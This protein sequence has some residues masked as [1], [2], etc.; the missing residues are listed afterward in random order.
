VPES[1]VL[2]DSEFVPSVQ[3]VWIARL[4]PPATPPPLA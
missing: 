1:A 4:H 2:P 3:R